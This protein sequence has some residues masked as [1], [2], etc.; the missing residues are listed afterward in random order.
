[1]IFNE[2]KVF[3]RNWEGFKDE[4]LTTD[5]D[6]LVEWTRKYA[7]LD[8][9]TIPEPEGEDLIEEDSPEETSEETQGPVANSIQ[10]ADVETAEDERSKADR[11]NGPYTEAKFTLLPT[12][13]RLPPSALLAHI[14]QTQSDKEMPSTKENQKTSP[15]QAA[16]I[17]GT[18]SARMARLEGKYLT[19]AQI[20]RRLRQGVK[21][22]RS[23]LPKPP[24]W[25]NNLDNHPLGPIFRQAEAGYLQSHIKMK[26][27][28]KILKKDRRTA[29]K[30][31]LDCM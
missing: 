14:I 26:S 17:A 27:W 31:I 8:N 5:I 21:L 19:K 29:G 10:E 15:W 22:K 30:Q 25:H 12:P 20:E 13:P 11:E 24:R 1:V 6:R 7:L 3:D 4:L 16:F 9:N 28:T 23:N 18:K 2:H